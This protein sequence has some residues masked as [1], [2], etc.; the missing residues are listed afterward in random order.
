MTNEIEL[1]GS[2]TAVIEQKRNDYVIKGVMGGKDVI[3]KR[4]VD[5]MKIPKTKKPTLTKAGAEAICQA[6]GVFQRFEIIH[7]EIRADEKATSFTF[8]VRC[9]LVKINPVDGKEWIVAQGLGAGSTNEKNNGLNGAFDSLNKVIKMCETRA[10]RDA[11]INL[12][13]A[14]SWFTQDL[15]N[16][17][18]MASAETLKDNLGDDAP[19]TAKQVKRLFAL[20]SQAG[21][22]TEEAKTKF[23]TLGYASTK[24]IKQR[25]YDKAC[26]LFKEPKE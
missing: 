5:F 14:S 22:S 10:K 20:A 23:M 25:D 1:Y 6:Y 12:A 17:E 16:D 21:Y 24:D 26:D 8:I 7:K 4:D 15:D 13:G 18:F 3:L 2:S 19:I 9:D 11:A